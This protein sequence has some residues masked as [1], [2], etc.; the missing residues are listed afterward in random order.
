MSSPQ[1]NITVNVDVTNPGQFF[2][3]CGLLE[4]AD[5][6]WPGAEGWFED[7]VFCIHAEGTL[8]ELWRAIVSAELQPLNPDDETASPMRLRSPF[9][10]TLDW[11]KDEYSGGRTLKAWAG[12]MRGV[13]IALAMKAAVADAAGHDSPFDY[14][15]VIYDPDNP[16]KKVEPYY[17]DSRRGWNAQPIDIGFSPDSLK[18]TSAAY[19]AV[20]F[21]CLI[22]LQ[23]FR[24]FPSTKRRVFDYHTWRTPFSPCLAAAAVSGVVPI[25]DDVGF[26]FENAFRTDQEKHKSFLPATPQ[27]AF[28]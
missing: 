22:G 27:G 4:L 23:R 13:R 5:R 28:T 19:P 17:F 24:P 18:M 3:C 16:K 14:A 15:S 11:W 12:S 21:L 2:A 9:D 20:E 8:P 1:P 7:A 26:R 25:A 6:F 10:L